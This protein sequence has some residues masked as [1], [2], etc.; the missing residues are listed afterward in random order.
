MLPT[1]LIRELTRLVRQGEFGWPFARVVLQ[2][3][4]WVIENFVL[5]DRP[6]LLA[7]E[8]PTE[9]CDAVESLTDSL[10]AASGNTL[11]LTGMSPTGPPESAAFWLPLLIRLIL[12]LLARS[13]R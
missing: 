9:C 3:S 1:E 11:A 13:K 2:L 10:D 12:E 8:D 6:D 5:D 4:I 7:S